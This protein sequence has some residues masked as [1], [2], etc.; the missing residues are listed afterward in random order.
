MIHSTK[1]R[2]QVLKNRLHLR[3]GQRGFEENCVELEAEINRLEEILDVR[4][5]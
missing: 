4:S 2:L 5:N 1:G 3:E